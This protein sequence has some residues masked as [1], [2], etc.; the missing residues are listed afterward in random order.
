MLKRKIKIKIHSYDVWSMD[1]TL[2]LVILPMLHKL[3]AVKHGSPFVEDEDVPE[4]IRSTNAMLTPKEYDTD[5]FFH[6]RWDWV[7]DELIWTFT[8][9]VEDDIRKKETQMRVDNGLRLFGRY[10]SGLW[11]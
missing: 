11:N 3:K 9:L 7:L 4:E 6:A 1:H 8:Q 2:S 10:Y 5:E